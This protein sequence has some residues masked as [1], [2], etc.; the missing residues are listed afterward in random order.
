MSGFFAHA[1]LRH[2]KG[3]FWKFWSGQAISTLGSSVT[4]F[5]LPLLVF[6]LTNSP[7]NLALTMVFTVLPFAAEGPFTHAW[8]CK[9]RRR[10]AEKPLDRKSHIWHVCSSKAPY[11]RK[12]KD[13]LAGE[14]LSSLRWRRLEAGT[15]RNEAEQPTEGEAFWHSSRSCPLPFEVVGL[16]GSRSPTRVSRKRGSVGTTGEPLGFSPQGVSERFVVFPI[17][18]DKAN[19]RLGEPRRYSGSGTH[20]RTA[21]A[22]D[23]QAKRGVDDK[24]NES[25]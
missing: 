24:Y 11:A 12:V 4:S 23:C 14:P 20:C 6:K 16:K 21:K 5:A 3:D 15:R 19:W 1:P 17:D 2:L 9:P 22:H 18:S 13:L 10:Q 25:H 8:G 7:L